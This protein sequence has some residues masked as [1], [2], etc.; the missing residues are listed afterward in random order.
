MSYAHATV[1]LVDFL[2]VFTID[3]HIMHDKQG[4]CRVSFKPYSTTNH[5]MAV[6]SFAFVRCLL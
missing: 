6:L 5:Q 1:C 3:G 4:D 2:Q